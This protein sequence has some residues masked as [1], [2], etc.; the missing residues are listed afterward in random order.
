MDPRAEIDATLLELDDLVLACDATCAV[1]IT[2]RPEEALN[3]A[4]RIAGQS[5]HGRV[6][7]CDFGAVATVEASRLPDVTGEAEVVLLREI[8]SLTPAQQMWLTQVL[9][10]GDTGCSRII[11]SSSVSLFNRVQEGLFD[12]RLFYRLNVVHLVVS[13]PPSPP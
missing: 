4:W 5:G 3:V 11:A 13:T 10:A 6:R 8:H 9:E 1:L 12:A 2:G 7:V